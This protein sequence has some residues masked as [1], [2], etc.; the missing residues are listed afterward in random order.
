MALQN[1][2]LFFE[3]P[4]GKLTMHLPGMDSILKP[5]LNSSLIL[6]LHGQPL[7]GEEL[8]SLGGVLGHF[9]RNRL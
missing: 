2:F 8:T 5:Q 1:L 3:T 9:I 7:H 4:T 6:G